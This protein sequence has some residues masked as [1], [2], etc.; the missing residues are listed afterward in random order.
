MGDAAR[1][2]VDAQEWLGMLQTLAQQIQRQQQNSQQMV[3]EMMDTYMQLLNTPGS[4]LSGQAEQQQQTLRQTAQQWMEQAQQQQQA[5]QQQ[6]QQQ[7]QAFQ[8]M[9]QE[10]LNTY[11][12]LFNIP[13]SY[14]QEG[15]RSARFPIEGYDEL[16]VDEV[17]A[18]LGNL[19]A[20]DLRVVRDY[21]ERNKNRDTIL[22]QLDGKIRAGS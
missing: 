5:F 12:Q 1:V 17:T 21:E 16:T 6:A 20:E 11:T 15:L 19:S 9:T 7:Q 18:R 14:A 22:Q 3:Q 13:I 2:P 4:Y 8:Q 10:V